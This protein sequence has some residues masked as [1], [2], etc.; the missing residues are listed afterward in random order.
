MALKNMIYQGT[1]LGPLLWNLFYER[2]PIQKASFTEVVY[3]DDLNGFR[4]FS[5]ETNNEDIQKSLQLCQR[6]LHA[7]GRA[8][9]VS[10]DASKESS[11]ILSLTD[12]VGGMFRLLGVSFDGELTM[13]DAVAEVVTE[14]G[15]KL[16]TLLRTQ[17]Y[18]T[19]ADLIVLYKSHVLSYLEYRT[20][21]VYHATRSVLD[22]L[23]EVQR[24]FLRNVGVDEETAL[25]EF[26][27]APLEMRRDIA[28]LGVIHRA[29]IKEGPPQLQ[30]LFQKSQ[31]G[32][33]V[34]DPF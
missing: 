28:M 14:A 12:S 31:G 13:A 9:Q 18:Y 4:I 3:A 6:E 16:R 19:D 33:R 29:S 23:D 27:L 24:R 7:W 22:K 5:A 21:A 10:F 17:R 30:Q 8:N 15:W 25:L 20:P 2:L 32:F 1:D 34:L 26:N 11:H